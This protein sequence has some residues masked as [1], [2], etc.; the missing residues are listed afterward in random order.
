M[1]KLKSMNHSE[2]KQSTETDSERAYILDLAHNDLKTTIINMLK[3]KMVLLNKH[4]GNLNKD[5]ETIKEEPSGNSRTE[6]HNNR[7]IQQMGSRESLKWQENISVKCEVKHQKFSNPKNKEKNEEKET[8]LQKPNG[9]TSKGLT[10]MCWSS[11][12]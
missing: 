2:K 6:K 11:R 10:Y 3:G 1:K 8:K 5:I 9:T 12:R 4:I 7:N